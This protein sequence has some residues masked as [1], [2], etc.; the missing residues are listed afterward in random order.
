MKIPNKRE[1]QPIAFNHSSEIEFYEF[2]N[3][4][5]KCTAKPYSFL[6]IDNTLVSH[7]PS[8]FRKNISE[9]I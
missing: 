7:N 4:Y 1:R 2:M 8:C 3:L 5:E 6:F 9:R